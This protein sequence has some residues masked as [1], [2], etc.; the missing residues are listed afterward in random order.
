M[1]HHPRCAPHEF[2]DG[3]REA[4]SAGA[5]GLLAVA[6]LVV[7]HG[8]DDGAAALVALRQPIEMALEVAFD[9]SLGFGHES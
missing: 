3:R 5:H 4:C 1:R 2:A 6:D 8:L 9:L 7:P